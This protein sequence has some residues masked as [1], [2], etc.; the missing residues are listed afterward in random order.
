MP[1]MSISLSVP[2]DLVRRLVDLAKTQEQPLSWVAT[3][4]LSRFLDESAQKDS[5]C[6]EV[7]G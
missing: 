4:A 1:H 6:E 7:A 3:T 2:A 5:D